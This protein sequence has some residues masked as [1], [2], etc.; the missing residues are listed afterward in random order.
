MAARVREIELATRYG[1]V[2]LS[3]TGFV[4]ATGDAGAD[5]RGGLRVPRA[6]GRAALRHADD[7]A[8]RHRRGAHPSRAEFV[9]RA[10]AK[11]APTAW[12]GTDGFAFVF[13]GRGTALVNMTHVETPLEPVAASKNALI[14]KAQADDVAAF[15]Q[16][17]ISRG[18]R[19]GAGAQLWPARHPP[20]ALDP[21]RQQLTVDDVRA[22]TKFPDAV[23]RTAWPIELHDRAGGLRLGAV[24]RRP[25][26]LCAVRQ[27][28]AGGG[29]QHRG[30][31]PLHRRRQPR[32]YRACASWDRAS[33]WGRPPRMRSI[34]R[35]AAACS[36]S[37]SRRSEAGGDNVERT[38]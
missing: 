25:H 19:Q 16:G 29:R 15:P 35:A 26:A 30:R 27:P 13:P 34:S 17:R 20:D 37:T 38:D 8:R 32:R 3:A 24:R 21:G 36:R 33:R 1:D 10:R 18:L 2:T 22:G 23:A 6:R 11:G 9:A 12:F 28:R 31:R 14:G 5:L 7:G 4:D